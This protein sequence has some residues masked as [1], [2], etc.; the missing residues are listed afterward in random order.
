MK[1]FLFYLSQNYSYAILRPLQEQILARGDQVRWFL[2][3]DAV[4]PE[5]LRENEVRLMTVNEVK[6]YQPD[7]VFVPGNVVPNFIPGIKVG[8]FHGFNAGKMNRR[9]RED[10]FEIRGCFDLYCTQGPN[11]TQRFKELEQKHKYFRVAETGWP[12]IDPLFQ[13]RQGASV[14]DKPTV[15][16]CST[17]SRNLTCAP[18]LLDTV[19]RLSQTGRWNWLVQFHPKMDPNVVKAYKEIQS[20][21]LSFVETDNVIP[22][23]QQADVMVC[24]TSS[25]LLMFLLQNKPVVTFKNTSPMSYMLDID[26]PQ[27][28]EKSIETALSRPDSLMK[29]IKQFIDELHPY[30]DGKSSQRVLEAVDDMLDKRVTLPQRNKP[31]N[32]IRQ[33]K[34]RKTLGYWGLG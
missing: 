21:H 24:D 10:H 18:V 2:E 34:M 5:Y 31:L 12:A 6:A 30:S 4:N 27:L 14:S 20:E 25:V 8:V 26:D 11:T 22:L 32:L 1:K 29:E 3:T 7:A 9:G 13:Q 19:K 28:L 17:F 23:L 16:L 33:Y 15:L